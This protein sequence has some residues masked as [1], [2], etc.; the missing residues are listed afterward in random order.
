MK[1]AV[2]TQAGAPPRFAEF[3]DPIADKGEQLITLSAAALSPLTRSRASG[4]HYSSRGGFPFVAG[5]D[6][7]G[8]LADGSRVYFALP[9]APYGAMAERTVVSTDRIIPL[10]SDLDDLTAAAIAN[11]GMSS[12]VAFQERAVLQRGETVLVNG[13][14]GVSGRLAVQIARHLGASRVIA[15]GRSLE[16]LSSVGADL[17]L[18]LEEGESQFEQAFAA[19]VDVVVDYLWGSSAEMLLRAAAKAR[20]G[21]TPLRF[22]QVGTASGAD[23][24]LP[25][26]VLRSSAITLMGSGIGSVPLDRLLAAVAGVLEAARA[27]G[28]STAATPVPLADVANAWART[29][30]RLV[31]TP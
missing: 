25:G 29:D 7:V 16:A 6:G 10:A 26:A 1:A 24:T 30:A 21:H 15:T 13:A 2:V 12:W 8:R 11:P 14:T 17:V 20:S 9:R 19:G 27:G 22:V 3:A 23:M 5:V 4:K 31:F 28:L 18:A